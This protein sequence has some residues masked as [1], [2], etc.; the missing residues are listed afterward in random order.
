MNNPIPP[1][2]SLLWPLKML[3]LTVMFTLGTLG[4]AFADDPPFP[5]PD[6]D[7]GFETGGPGGGAPIGGGVAILLTLG[8]AY[9]GRKAFIEQKDD[10]EKQTL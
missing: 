3:L 4:T 1:N 5:D 8:A 6:P 10:S 2:R 9:A 7:P